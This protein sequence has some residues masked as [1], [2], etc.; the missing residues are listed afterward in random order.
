MIDEL[1]VFLINENSGRILHKSIKEALP[2]YQRDINVH[3][4]AIPLDVSPYQTYTVYVH[5]TAT[6][7]KNSICNFRNSSFLSDIFR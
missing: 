3:Q 5:L 7:A 2:S 4:C 1:N 6:D